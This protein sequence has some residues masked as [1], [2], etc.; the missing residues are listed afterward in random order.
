MRSHVELRHERGKSSCLLLG[1]VT[2]YVKEIKCLI[3]LRM[4]L[5]IEAPLIIIV[6]TKPQIPTT[7]SASKYTNNY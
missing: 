5:N 4:F 3:I 2:T 1:A 7:G 6:D